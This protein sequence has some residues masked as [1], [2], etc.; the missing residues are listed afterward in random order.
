M[1]RMHQ[2]REAVIRVR[3]RINSE[4]SQDR[5]AEDLDPNSSWDCQSVQLGAP[6][7]N[8]RHAADLFV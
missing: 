8:G 5:K 2:E 6:D 1:L 4:R 3:A 7:C